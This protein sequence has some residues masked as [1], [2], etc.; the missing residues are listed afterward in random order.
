MVHLPG[1]RLYQMYICINYVINY[2]V[3]ESFFPLSKILME[4][5]PNPGQL[6]ELTLSV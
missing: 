3:N 4:S 1:N 6:E 2:Y 5:C